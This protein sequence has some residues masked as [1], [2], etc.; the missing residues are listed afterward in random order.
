MFLH[1]QKHQVRNLEKNVHRLSNP[2]IPFGF[3]LGLR[4]RARADFTLG[5]DGEAVRDVDGESLSL[6]SAE[7]RLFNLG[8]SCLN[9]SEL[10]KSRLC[11]SVS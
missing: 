2:N 11:V 9:C 10:V 1:R 4:L 7:G 5:L 8:V 6:L 3:L